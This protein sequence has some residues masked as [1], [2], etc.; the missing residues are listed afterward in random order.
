M[1]T[2]TN[3]QD[4]GQIL[5]MPCFDKITGYLIAR[6]NKGTVT[7]V[8]L[9]AAIGKSLRAIGEWVYHSKYG[10]QF[11][12]TQIDVSDPKNL[13]GYINFLANAGI[14]GLG[15][16]YA[17]KLV[18]FFGLDVQQHLGNADDLKRA[19]IPDRLI[20]SIIEY[21]EK[22]HDKTEYN[23]LLA[24][25]GISGKTATKIME[26]CKLP[27]LKRNPYALAGKIPRLRFKNLDAIHLQLHG[28]NRSD[29]RIQAGLMEAMRRANDKG[30]SGITYDDLL[31]NT[32]KLLSLDYYDIE[33]FIE[34]KQED[35]DSLPI[36]RYPV[37]SP[38]LYSDDV[39]RT[40]RYIATTLKTIKLPSLP[41]AI[42]TPN[43]TDEQRH[44]VEAVRQHPV[45]IITGGPGTG[46]THTIKAICCLAEENG[47]TPILLAPTGLAARK[48]QDATGRD[49]MTIHRFLKA[50]EIDKNSLIIVDETS[51]VS[52]DVQAML[53][54]A[55][56]D[57][58]IRI[59]FVGDADQLPSIDH[60]Q[61]L[62]DLINSKQFPVTTLTKNHRVEGVEITRAAQMILN[63]ENPDLPSDIAQECSFIQCE[64]DQIASIILE[65][66]SKSD[67]VLSP[68]KQHDAGTED[69]NALLADKFNPNQDRKQWGFAVGD[70]VINTKNDY[71]LG[72]MN[73]ET[74]V[75]RRIDKDLVQVRYDG[76]Y[77][78]EHK[79]DEHNLLLAYALTVHKVQ[80]QEYPC[81]IIALPAHANILLTRGLLYTAMTR[82]KKKVIIVGNPKALDIILSGRWDGDR[83]TALAAHLIDV[84]MSCQ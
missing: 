2:T 61:V 16:S 74:G 53:L 12:A 44:A 38:N 67:Q 39:F 68:V 19:G 9:N 42:D 83:I 82:A 21:H 54:K 52:L 73:G 62:K 15:Q 35:D 58:S 36:I 77:K 69:L 24:R 41:K 66:V 59:V 1:N 4:F 33:G 3:F 31:W 13:N 56:Q 47:L 29:Q 70:R 6:T 63:G 50:E 27:E 10:K 48:I 7:G 71:K 84:S 76:G 80:G 5:S 14:P 46:K 8:A 64:D 11:K 17:K 40:E 37:D 30:D 32:A 49:A 65:L 28:D 43:L 57:K 72:V 25:S 55:L 75:I 78:V 26:H 45:S 34:E 18:D 51:M 60:G 81:V 22:N 20:P 79:Y 23:E